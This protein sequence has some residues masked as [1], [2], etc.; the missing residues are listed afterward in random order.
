MKGSVTFATARWIVPRLAIA[1]AIAASSMTHAAPAP[2]PATPPAAAPT[3]PAPAPALPWI[4]R[5]R[6]QRNVIELGLAV[7]AL[8]PGADHE[9]YDHTRTWRP[10]R[11][12]ASLALRAGFYPLRALGVEAE[13]GLAPTR[14]DAG[15]PA[16][17]FGARGQIVAQLPLYSV[18]PFA[19]AGAGVLGAGGALGRDVDLSLHFG[20]GLKIFASRWVGAR[21]DARA[22]LGFAHTAAASRTVHPEVMV[23][24]TINLN[25]P[26]LDTDHDGVPDPG[27]RAKVEDACPRERGK[28]ALRGC[29][30]RDDDDLRDQ[31]DRCPDQ[32]GLRE[33][34]GCPALVDRDGDGHYDPGQHKL[35][36]GLVDACPDEPGVKEYGGCKAP[37]S[38]GDGPDD[39]ADRCPKQPET[40]NGFEDDDGCPDQLPLDVLKILGTI[41]GIQFGFLS[42]RLADTS[43]PILEQTAKILAEYPELRLEIQGHT[44]SDG[45]PDANKRLSQ[46]RAE[47][48]RRVLIE[49]GVA[50]ERLR[51]A[52]YGGEQPDADNTTEAGRVANRRI[53]FCLVD[54]RGEPLA[55]EAIDAKP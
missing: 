51:A 25:R 37:D 19:L 36:A 18:A 54:A 41:R 26:Y 34:D 13:A 3:S 30:D 50:E 8:I 10:Y 35:P 27:Q 31:D 42:A 38:D 16:R 46:R 44:D 52:G 48:V 28:R 2:T 22:H 33:R 55:L 43:R 20:G 49:F 39:L 53:E 1:G 21:I 29:P 11:P 4:S 9:L 45:D 6:P 5:H 17:L 23:S 7:G 12:A 15:D 14:T 32:T 40:V 47:S 24:L